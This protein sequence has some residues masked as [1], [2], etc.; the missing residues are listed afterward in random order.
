[1][2]T[3][4]FQHDSHE[5]E[6]KIAEKLAGIEDYANGS[7][8]TEWTRCVNK[9][10]LEL[11]TVHSLDSGKQ[12]LTACKSGFCDYHEWLWD[13]VWYENNKLGLSNI[14]LIA[15]SE[16]KNARGNVDYFS[17]FQVDFEKLIAG[18]S[19]YRLM[20]FEADNQAECQDFFDR[21]KNLVKECKLSHAGDRY[22][23]AAW[24]MDKKE[25]EFDMIVIPNAP[26]S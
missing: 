13:F 1:M 10:L 16:W 9:I 11:A 17:E 26:V 21:L 18:R 15:E 25:F 2:K 20:I 8:G 6:N 14:E 24:L 12:I 22:M 7:S 23:L 3:K 19:S 4:S 5:L